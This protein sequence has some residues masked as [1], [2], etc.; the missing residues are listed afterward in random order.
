[1]NHIFSVVWNSSLQLWVVASELASRAGRLATNVGSTRRLQQ[2][3]IGT[4]A[5]DLII[6]SR[7]AKWSA[8]AIAV[9]L[10]LNSA[11]AWAACAPT[12]VGGGTTTCTGTDQITTVGSGPGLNNVTINVDPAAQ[13]STGE[14]TAISVD[15]N[16]TIDLG[17]NALVQNDSSNTNSA[18]GLFSAGQNTIEFNSNTQLTLQAGAIVSSLG[19]GTQNAAVAAFGASNAIINFG[20]IQGTASSAIWFLNRSIGIANTLDNYGIIRAQGTAAAIGVQAGTTGAVQFINHTGGTVNGNVLLGDGNDTVTL[21]TGSILNGNVDGAGGTNTFNLSSIN[22][23]SDTMAGNISN[24]QTVNKLGAGAWTLSGNL[25]NTGANAAMAVKVTQ[26]QLTLSGTNT[27]AGGTTISS[28]G[29][30]SVSADANMGAAALNIGNVTLDGGT[31]RSTANFIAS[32]QR[33]MTITGNNGTIQTDAGV[34]FNFPSLISG[35]GSLTKTGTGTL[36]LGTGNS[37]T[38]G[39][40]ITAGTVVVNNNG[41]FGAADT[42]VFMNDG[43]KL[44]T[45]GTSFLTRPF[46]LGGAVTFNTPSDLS[47]NGVISGVGPLIKTGTG[48]LALSNANTYTG[49]TQLLAGSM[50]IGTN[51]SIVGNVLNNGILSFT[52]T[53]ARTFSGVISGTGTLFQQGSNRLVLTGVNTFTGSTFVS[54]GVMEVSQAANLGAAT[55]SVIMGGGILETTDSFT[56]TRRVSLNSANGAIQ[57]GGGT[58]LTAT[59]V[60][61]AI[62]NNPLN[63]TGDG[64]LV[65]TAANTYAGPT[66]VSAGTLQIGNGGATGSIVGNVANNAT[67]VFNRS[68]AL[69][70]A[71]AISGNGTLNQIG[72]GTTQLTGNSGTFSGTTNVTNGTLQV[73]GT[74][75]S[76]ASS[77]SVTS[78]GTLSGNGVLGGDVSIDGG[79]LAPGKLT[80]N[81]NLG[82][83]GASVLNYQLGQANS[84][85]SPLNNLVD[86]GGNLTLDGTLNV[87]TTP[88]GNFGP[89]LYNLINYSGILTNN[90]L[91]LGTMPVGS[92][93]FLQTSYAN[94][95]NLVNT[96]GLTLN[97]WDGP[98]P[99]FNNVV[100]GGSGVWQNAQGNDGWTDSTGVVNAPYTSGAF[101]IFGGTAGTVTVDN[102]LGDITSSGMQFATSG[103]LLQGDPITLA[104]GRNI[105]RVGDGGAARAGFVATID[106]LLSGAGGVEKTDLGT[107]VLGGANSYTG[108]T[109]ISGGTLSVSADNNLG[110][111]A[112]DVVLN[113]GTLQ[114]T[115]SFTTARAFDV[116]ANHGTVQTDTG[117]TLITNG[118]FTGS[119]SLTKT[120]AGTLQL[121]ADNAYGGNTT[122]AA[123]TLQLGSGGLT[124]SLIGDVVNNGTLIVERSNT[125]N[126]SGT[127]GGS[128]AFN[129]AG[130]GTTVLTGNNTY[131]GVTTISGGTLQLG[132]G[133]ATGSVVGDIV[134]DGTLIFNRT[135]ALTLDGSIIG[136]GT[137][138]HNGSGITT[139]NGDSSNFTGDTNVSNG[140]LVVNGTLGAA[141]STISVASGGALDGNGTIGGNV[142]VADGLLTSTAL[143][144]ITLTING[145]LTLSNNSTMDYQFGQAN[146]SGGVFNDLT[147]VGGN[148]TLDGILNVLVPTGGDFGPGIYRVISYGGTLVDNGLV[149]GTVPAN[150]IDYI[151]TGFTGQVNLV[152]TTGLVLNYWDGTGPEFN[153]VVN[154]GTGIWQGAA[155]NTL[156]ADSTGTLNAAYAADAF[157]IFGGAPGTVTVDNSLGAVTSSGMQFIVDGYRIE[158]GPITLVGDTNFIRVGD[159]TQDGASYVATI[160]SELNGTGGVTLSGLGTLV[161][162]GANDYQGGTT[163]Q[164]ATLQLGE[165]GTSGSII[166]DVLNNGKLVFDRSDSSSVSGVIGGTGAV[167]QIGTGTTVLTATNSYSGG[168]TISAGTLQLGD[169]GNTGSII[170]DV[171]NDGTLAFN[172]SDNTA[173]SG[174][175]SGTGAVKQVGSGTTTLS[176]DNSYQGGTTIAVGTLA[177]SATSFGSGA[178]LNDATL[179]INQ[180]T[181]AAFSNT[182]DGSGSLVKNGA[183]TL[184]LNGAV[185]YTGQ[186]DI[187]AG[188]LVLG[189]NTLASQQVNVAENAFLAGVSRVAGAI[190]N[191]GTLFVGTQSQADTPQISQFSAIQP[192]SSA[193]V[194]TIGTDLNN[195]G[196]VF[197]GNKASEGNAMAGNQLVINGNY[198]GNNGLLHFNTALGDDTSATDSMIVKGNS[199]GTTRVSVDN[200]GGLGAQT[201]EGIELIQVN[202]LSGGDFVQQGRIVAGAYDYSLARGTGTN[203]ANWYLTSVKNSNDDSVTRP[204]AGSYAANLAAANSMFLTRLYDRSGETQYIDAITGEIKVTSMWLRNQGG[205]NRFR[206]E[207]GQLATQSNRYVLQLGGEIG[208]WSSN[209]LDGFHLGAM[210][211]YGNSKSRTRSDHSDYR[212]DGSVNG[213]SLG[214][215]GTWYANEKDK[216]G[217]Y[218]DSWAQYSW[219]NNRVNGQG[220]SGENY[221][222]KGVTASVESGYTFKLGENSAKDVAYFIQPKAQMVWMGVKADRHTE[223]NGTQVTGEGN[224]NLQTRLGARAYTKVHTANASGKNLELQPFVEVNWLHN[225]KNFGVAMDGAK[226]TQAGAENIG[227]LK[228]GVEGQVNK[229]LSVWSNVGVQVGNAGYN[230]TAVMLGVKYNF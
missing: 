217:L 161:L 101:A 73:N 105:I 67:L 229:K 137:I 29:T 211:G 107:L 215:Y 126:L 90:G 34:T 51:G 196:T 132:D 228:M 120:G 190:N 213:Y 15:S 154:G 17:S 23:T 11:G 78:G 145:D 100:N 175:I 41:A 222:S 4:V 89:G 57:T 146:V 55:G 208:Q 142:F 66:T 122:I 97:Y 184:S 108:G 72:A 138:Q 53:S 140:L 180:A 27:Y 199:S 155:G 186:T 153:G 28:G 1:M 230:D 148:L 45:S 87:A 14:N 185:T 32:N 79:I 188:G 83:T 131:S 20:T 94:Q 121:N 19:T 178:I 220:L 39:T 202:G 160:E 224:G 18:A 92:T 125:L 203:V 58:T 134:D 195:S 37:F 38:G 166:G 165:G 42:P 183:G 7:V 99:K 179:I 85:G 77:L 75:G 223:A 207:S 63:K 16:S 98:G 117:V 124:G 31:L 118:A 144:P 116:T 218:V 48:Y 201:V 119:G 133:G 162:T 46:T 70:Y 163:I 35:A 151:Q 189:S 54:S 210:A 200:A 26:G 80:I 64:T 143:K 5:G 212:S 174:V 91:T 139:L 96:G 226:V 81:G 171:V 168:T 219:F 182:I 50:Q 198:T 86:V 33:R 6:G 84:V 13:I 191:L 114:G 128:G 102:S 112:G 115:A 44:Q 43:T 227:E 36:Q 164:D 25:G 177:G 205:H 187:N 76:T 68:N 170:G 225:T 150:T 123:G 181:D 135:G 93:P 10:L 221:K 9:N 173:F 152:N 159:G 110:D 62:G 30:L 47:F 214:L 109:T 61:S 193:N 65:F 104:T 40:F 141:G 56:L 113:G 95:I 49:G 88:G 129:Q 103:Y 206:D 194:L 172:R 156:W 21:D 216:L 82:L 130:S 149:L 209:S 127:I 157:A 106:A 3:S 8:T 169:G 167:E 12:P 2:V 60:F 59:G 71:G 22:G 69:S 197:I 176:N 111:S 147:V 52:G 204:E 74:L 136:S 192:A 158:G 24:F